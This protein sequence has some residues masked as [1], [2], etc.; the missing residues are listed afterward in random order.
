MRLHTEIQQ[1]LED[2]RQSGKK[3][4]M[5]ILG[6]TA[7]GK[8]AL[9]IKLAHQFNG[10]IISADSRQIFRYMDIG[11]DKIPVSKQEGIPHYLLD[12]VDPKEEFTLADYK[13]NAL[14]IISEIHKRQKLPILCGGTGLYLN[15]IIENYQ[16]PQVA[17]QY[18]LRQ[19]LAEYCQKHGQLALHKL[20]QQSDPEAAAR[21][22]PNNV[23]YVIR[24]LEINM[25]GN[26]NKKDSK[27]EQLYCTFSIGIEWPRE[28]LYERINQRV[29]NQLERG[30][31]NEVKMLLMK[32][33]DEKLPS[34]TSLGYLELISYIK[35]ECTLEQAVEKIKQNTRNY[36]KRQITWFKRYK[37]IHWLTPEILWNL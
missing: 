9:S 10:E 25:A 35:G 24:A 29:D 22:H 2:S 3:T 8:T 7:S 19:K 34:M 30:L 15:S 12:V 4:M 26:Q 5:V 17:P 37:N 31:L 36:A 20:L 1:F 6:P 32:S 13:H 33:Y 23:R 27:G 14:K 28:A 11:T 18:D 21:I 16:I